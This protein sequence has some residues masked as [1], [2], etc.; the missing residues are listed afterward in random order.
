MKRILLSALLLAVTTLQAQ[1]LLTTSPSGGNKKASVTERIGI[2]DVTIRYDRPAVKSREGKIWGQLVPAGY[3]D[4]QFGTRKASPW[5]AGA[6][7]S[8]TIEF[9]TDVTIEGQPLSKGKYGFFIAYDPAQSTL[10]FSKA[11]TNWGSYYYDPKDDVLRVNVKPVTTDRSVEWL[12]YEFTNQTETAATISLQWEKL[13]FPFTVE[14]DLNK[15]QVESFR[16]ELR[17]DKGF[18]WLPWQQAAQWCLDR[19]TNLEEALRWAD[20]A[21]NP[22]VLGEK[23][24]TTL[25]TKAQIL[26]KLNR[27]AEATAIMKEATPLGTI[28]QVHQYGKTLLTQKRS[29]EALE[30]FKSN[31]EKFPNQFTTLAG[32]VRG[33]SAVGDYRK[34]LEYAEKALPLSPNQLNTDSMTKMI[35]QLKE[36]KDVN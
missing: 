31:Y 17:T 13:S 23:N 15:T 24:F 30:V 28:S 36:G 27:G 18:Y 1:R 25:A 11:T 19:N 10:I 7:E 8:T 4:L 20:T 16:T 29:K 5:R 26:E 33:Y 2:T 14:V 3:T 35:Q 9:S 32:L 21:T 34:A 6:N 22:G 12:K